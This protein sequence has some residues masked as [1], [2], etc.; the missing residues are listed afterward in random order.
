MLFSVRYGFA[1]NSSSTHSIVYDGDHSDNM[2]CGM[3]FGWETFVC[4]SKEAKLEYVIASIFSSIGYYN[5]KYY[6]DKGKLKELMDDIKSYFGHLCP[7]YDKYDQI[8]E[9]CIENNYNIYVDHQSLFVCPSYQSGKLCIEYFAKKFAEVINN[10]GI[11]IHGGNDN[12]GQ[13]YEGPGS[14]VELPSHL[15]EN[16]YF[17]REESWGWVLFNKRNGTKIVELHDFVKDPESIYKNYSA[18]DLVD[19]SI[20]NYCGAECDFCYR[21]SSKKGKHADY[22]DTT[23]IIKTLSERGV[24]EVAIGGGEPLSHPNILDILETCRKHNITPNLTTKAFDIFKFPSLWEKLRGLCGG[25]GVSVQDIKDLER[26]PEGE[27]VTYHIILEQQT[28]ESLK[29]ITSKIERWGSVLLLGAKQCGRPLEVNS[30]E[31]VD[32]IQLIK[33]TD[34]NLKV[35]VDSLI[36][37][38]YKNVLEHHNVP[39]DRYEYREG[40]TSKFI[41]AVEYKVFESSYTE[42]EGESFKGGKY[43]WMQEKVLAELLKT[44]L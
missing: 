23:K 39:K 12:G 10:S 11:T 1:T 44:N 30:W 21:K 16:P 17:I 33:D 15:N 37:E 35:G 6:D 38:R 9:S 2:I 41:D 32:F 7:N 26:I 5:T 14:E 13:R 34:R 25:I 40:I 8:L 24:L 19:L 42:K 22:Y 4:A 18:P 29:K 27:G 20:T 43:D 31:N 3:G 28:T 36:V